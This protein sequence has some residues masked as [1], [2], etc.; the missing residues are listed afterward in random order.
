MRSQPHSSPDDIDITSLWSVL[1]RHGKT[2][3]AL[4]AL[5]GAGTYGILSLQPTKYSSETQLQI[6]SQGVNDP[7]RDPRLGS[8]PTMA[9]ATT[10]V[11]KEAIASQVVALKSHDLAK[12]LVEELRLTEREE[13]NQ[14]LGGQKFP[15]RMLHMLGVSGP[16]GGETPE[17]STLT[18]YYKA[19]Q[20]AQVRDT[21]VITIEFTSSDNKLAADGANRLAEFYQQWLRTRVV[22]ETEDASKWLKPQIESLAKE[23]SQAEADVERFRSKANLF[24]GGGNTN[25]SLNEQQLSDLTTE[26]TK[27]RGGRSDAEAR[28]R[29]ARE[30]MQRGIADAITEVQKSPVIQGLIAQRTRAEREKAEAETSLLPGHPRMKQLNANVTDLRRQVNKEASLIVD[31]LEK[32][33]KALAIREELAQKNLDGVKNVV[34]NKAVEMAELAALEGLAK[35]KRSELESLQMKEQAARTRGGDV[36]SVPLEAQI[37]SKAVVS[38]V[39]SSPK[40]MQHSL[41]AAA[42]GLI[43]GFAMVILKELFSS[44]HRH[45]PAQAA[46]VVAPLEPLPPMMSAQAAVR[47]AMPASAAGPLAAAAAAPATSVS[48]QTSASIASRLIANAA[49]KGGYRTVMTGATSQVCAREH[50]IDLAAALADEGKQ[51]V[52]VDWSTDGKGLREDLGFEPGLGMMDLLAG[53]ASFGDVIRRMPHGDAHII[54]CGTACTVSIASK[55]DCINFVLDALDEAYDHVVVTGVNGSIRD[56]FLVIQGRFDA[57]I[58]VADPS[59]QL[60]PGEFGDNVYVGFQVTDIDVI[61]LG[62]GGQPAPQ[63]AKMQLVHDEPA[64]ARA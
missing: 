59:Q 47:R 34:G 56:L 23:V 40:R 46:T 6:S 38:N 58:V 15:A 4:S 63:R 43:L 12:K 44:A 22:T 51:V 35:A 39:P 55:S 42:A 3:L 11:D 18:G 32:E 48:E 13:F 41:L 2:I 36:R 7:F 45:G 8:N 64:E 24:R 30:L 10:R 25:A 5:L 20:V 57:A 37:I 19:L 28:A 16:R 31:G 33:A 50:A 53:G 1:K 60:P 26:L 14:H 52:L 61:V 29:S 62:P 27:A 54:P 9:D 21:R 49:G 17:E